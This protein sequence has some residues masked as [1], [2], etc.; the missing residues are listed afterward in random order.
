[1]LL[2]KSDQT[3][4]F[5]TDLHKSPSLIAILFPVWMTVLIELGLQPLD[6][7][8]GYWQECGQA[9]VGK[10]V[11]QKGLSYWSKSRGH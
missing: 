7:L 2:V 4:R 10:V 8:K 11:G 5:C 1:M 6:L 9:K 3:P